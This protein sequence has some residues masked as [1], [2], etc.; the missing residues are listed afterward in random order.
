MALADSV[1]GLGAAAADALAQVC[2]AQRF[3]AF[4]GAAAFAAVVD[5]EVARIVDAD[6][7]A[8]RAWRPLAAW[9]ACRTKPPAREA[10]EAAARALQLW[11]DLSGGVPFHGNAY[12]SAG[13]RARVRA[14]R[15]FKPR[16]PA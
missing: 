13:A 11:D 9:R 12:A 8:R 7:A 4:A 16:P 10:N 14:R 2:V 3:D 5:A 6:G 15:R 1:A